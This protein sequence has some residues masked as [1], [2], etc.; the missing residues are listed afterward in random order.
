VIHLAAVSY[1]GHG[2]PADFYTANVI[3][4]RNL[5]EVL[6][7]QKSALKKVMLASSANVYGNATQSVLSESVAPA[8]ANDYAVSKLAMEHMAWLW[9][10]RLPL[11]VT[12]PFNYTGIGQSTRFL[13]A[14]IVDHYRRRANVIKLGNLE[15]ARDFSDVRY[16][17]TAY[18]ALL[19]SE[20]TG[21]TVNLCSGNSWS[22]RAIL[23]MCEDITGHKIEVQVDPALVRS[24]EVTKLCG[25]N[26]QLK[27]F[28][29]HLPVALSETL[30]WMLNE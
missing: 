5:L 15:I 27:K 13:I 25:D 30:E 1:V 28:L 17:A 8:P 20:L 3:G 22:L 9:A 24:S 16:I 26:T 11:L 4:T 12:R 21:T 6:A 29:P 14:K 2:N 7:E 23:Q 18:G 19:S 10:D